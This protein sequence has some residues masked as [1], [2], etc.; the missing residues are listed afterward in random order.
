MRLFYALI[1]IVCMMIILFGC[2][3]K[4]ETI[5]TVETLIPRDTIVYDT[6]IVD[7]TQDTINLY[8]TKD[9]LV[10]DTVI[11]IVPKSNSINWIIITTSVIY[12]TTYKVWA[13]VESLTIKME[14][15]EKLI[16]DTITIINDNMDDKDTVSDTIIMNVDTLFEKNIIYTDPPKDSILYTVVDTPDTVIDTFFV[17]KYL[18]ATTSDSLAGSVSFSAI[19]WVF[20]DTIFPE[21]KDV[22]PFNVG[23]RVFTYNNSVY[24]TDGSDSL[25]CFRSPVL[26]GSSLVYHKK[27]GTSAGFHDISFANDSK[28]FITQYNKNNVLVINPATGDSTG[29]ID[30]AKYG[31]NAGTGTP[32]LPY[33]QCSKFY[34]NILYVLC[35]RLKIGEGG[36]PVAGLL[37]GLVV[38][39]STVTDSV[40]TISLIR[41]KPLSMDVCNG[42]LYIA[43]AG[44]GSVTEIG[45][46]EKIDLVSGTNSVDVLEVSGI[47]DDISTIA[48]VS[49]TKGYLLVRTKLSGETKLFEFDPS[50]GIMGDEIA[51]IENASGGMDYD[52]SYIYVGDRSATNPGVVIINPADNS[53]VAGP[54]KMGLNP[55]SSVSVM[56]VS[57]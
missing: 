49:D 29:S 27:P 22:F 24:I 16:H 4:R 18:I 35:Q 54:V 11:T 41:K 30:L 26:S 14:I 3:Q 46:V 33:L 51:N 45:G 28:A 47:A 57:R 52:G 21:G 50:T 31:M 5:F 37:P 56:T 36:L 39:V 38:A 6:I 17:N 55:P 32:E 12:D 44:S 19:D 9:S 48:M 40:D 10:S 8:G 1:S 23:S 43:S 20:L 13:I 15:Y 53:K 25:A 42:Y 2:A 34:N 7:T